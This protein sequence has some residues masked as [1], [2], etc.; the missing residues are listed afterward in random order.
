MSIVAGNDKKFLYRDDLLQLIFYCIL[1]FDLL[2]NEIL[3]IWSN[4]IQLDVT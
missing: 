3:T 4:I 2:S 1:D